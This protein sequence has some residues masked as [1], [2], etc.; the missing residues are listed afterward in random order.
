[1]RR[2]R[3]S[4]ELAL[5]VSNQLLIDSRAKASYN[6][7]KLW[8][9][10]VLPDRYLSLLYS[11]QPRRLNDANSNNESAGSHTYRESYVKKVYCP[12][13]AAA[14]VLMM[15]LASH[16]VAQP[17]RGAILARNRSQWRSCAKAT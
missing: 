7:T 11:N 6:P 5:R 8:A 16:A 2:G 4:G 1:M 10:V 12:Y 17:F 15:T 13:L 14:F 3:T 9:S